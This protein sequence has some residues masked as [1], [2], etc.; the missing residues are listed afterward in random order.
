MAVNSIKEM[1][2]CRANDAEDMPNALLSKQ[3]CNSLVY[4][5][6]W[7]LHNFAS[8]FLLVPFVRRRA[9]KLGGRIDIFEFSPLQLYW[10]TMSESIV[11]RKC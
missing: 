8:V 6:A 4:L 7:F 9:R 11:T 5:L 2:I 10:L 3:A 1:S